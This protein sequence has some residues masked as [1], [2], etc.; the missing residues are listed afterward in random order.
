MK[1]DTGSLNLAQPVSQSPIGG[2]AQKTHSGHHDGGGDH[3]QI[4]DMAAQL[5]ADPQKLAQLGAAYANG[6]YQ[7]S[8][9]QI[10]NSLISEMMA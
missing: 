10:A 3:V 5:S 4:S 1:I 9:S 6:T 8:P 7:V 2:G